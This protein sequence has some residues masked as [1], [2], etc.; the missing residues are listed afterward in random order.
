MAALAPNRSLT[1]PIIIIVIIIN[2][3]HP[4]GLIINPLLQYHPVFLSTTPS[5]FFCFPFF[6]TGLQLS[7][8]KPITSS[9]STRN[10][11]YRPQPVPTPHIKFLVLSLNPTCPTPL[12]DSSSLP[13]SLPP[14]GV[15]IT[16]V[17]A[18]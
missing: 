16:I 2:N 9:P 18:H 15:I 7:D 17:T 4:Q 8:L 12:L 10:S 6:Y 3:N 11:R 14:R 1:P 13:K 5:R